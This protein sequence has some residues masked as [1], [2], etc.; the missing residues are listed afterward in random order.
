MDEQGDTTRHFQGIIELVKALNG[1]P[2]EIRSHSYDPEAFGSWFVTVRCNGVRLRVVFDGRDSVYTMQ[3]ST[4]RKTPDNWHDTEWQ[5]NDD[6]RGQIPIASLVAE[7]AR[8][9]NMPMQADGP[10]GR[11]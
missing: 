9:A 7:V 6:S 10:T 4:S 8:Q 3:R 11:R 1:L 2:A 5:V